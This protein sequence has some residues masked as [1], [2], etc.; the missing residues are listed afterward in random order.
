MQRSKSMVP[1]WMDCIR[2]SAPTMSAPAALASSALS[3][4]AKTATRT[5]L[6]VP[7]GRLTVPRTIW[8]AWRGSTPRLTAIS[9]VS[10]NFAVGVGLDQ[11]DRVRDREVLLALE[12]RLSGR[13]ALSDLRHQPFTSM[14]MDFAEPMMVCMA[15]STSIALRSFIFAVGDLA[16]LREGHGAGDVLAGLDRRLG[17][18]ALAHRLQPRRLLEE[19]GRGRRLELE[20]EALV[21]VVGDHDGRRRARPRSRPC[22][23]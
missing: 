19:V 22:A 16:H 4:R 10:S 9:T 1:P 17:P 7:L 14:P 6:P 2:S 8:S 18:V 15:A 21:G 3:P 11:R 12:R 13:E 20:R 23:R 5:V